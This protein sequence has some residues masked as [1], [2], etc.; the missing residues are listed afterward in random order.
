MDQIKEKDNLT[1]QFHLL[2]SFSDSIAILGPEGNM[3]FANNKWKEFAKVKNVD[4]EKYLDVIGFFKDHYKQNIQISDETNDIVQGI[5]DVIHGKKEHVEIEYSPQC[6]NQKQWFN[7]KI[8]PISS[9]FPTCAMLQYIDV[10]S[11]N[12]V[13]EQIVKSEKLYRLLANNTVDTIWTM[14]FDFEFTYVNPAIHDLTGFTPEEWTGSK[15]YEHCDE[16]NFAIMKNKVENTIN[17]LPDN[18]VVHFEATLLKKNGDQVPIEINGKVVFDKEGRPSSLQ[19]ATKDISERK[20][21]E[22]KLIESEERFRTLSDFSPAGI[23]CTDQHGMY[24]YVNKAWCEIADMSSSEAHKSGWKNGLYPEDKERILTSWNKLIEGIDTFDEE[25]RFI[26]GNGDVKWVRG[27]AKEILSPDNSIGY[28]GVTIDITD[29]K[30]TEKALI[31]AKIEAEKAN[32]TKSEFLATM[33]HE[34]RTPLNAIMGFSEI[35]LTKRPGEL[36]QKQ[37]GY[38]SNVLKGARHLLGIINDILDIS[39]IESGEN[40]VYF[41]NLYISELFREIYDILF[42][43]AKTKNISLEFIIE[44]SELT[45]IA[46]RSKMKQI[47]YNLVN[48]AIKFSPINGII[49][50]EAVNHS[51]SVDFYV[52]DNG[53]G[54][55]N[56]NLDIIFDP[57]KQVDSSLSRNF[58]GIGLGLP[59]SKHMVK[60][61]GGNIQ[62]ESEEGKG[63]TFKF[64]IPKKPLIKT[65]TIGQ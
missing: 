28:I 13:K 17:N 44:D 27:L 16:Q 5:R 26:D 55:P 39:K 21:T 34:L 37:T 61:H 8:I 32:R 31:K 30:N 59:I 6:P 42:P 10:T 62:V 7:L 49:Q 14:N 41:E 2:N 46:D 25:Y 64:T 65:K 50:V 56:D 22:K 19:G 18:P 47:I 9:E 23:Y 58:G 43:L 3:V 35:L 1:S 4:P 51:D 54:I 40:T 57:F 52:K 11:Q 45:L 15:L 60:L 12:I 36:N 24:K 38:L 33:S 53:I 48:N 20:I 63:S 29:K